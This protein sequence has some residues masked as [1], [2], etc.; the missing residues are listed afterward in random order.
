[1]SS[2][3][4][5]AQHLAIQD[6]E[7]PTSRCVVLHVKCSDRSSLQWMHKMSNPQ[8]KV[9]FPP[10][11]PEL[12]CEV[13]QEQSIKTWPAQSPDLSLFANLWNL[14]KGGKNEVIKHCFLNLCTSAPA[15][16]HLPTKT[17]SCVSSFISQHAS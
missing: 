5:F 2:L 6:L 3:F 15:A 1:M 10:I 8:R 12:H 17:M 9:G 11:N 13:N 16:H 14:S 4:S 7:R